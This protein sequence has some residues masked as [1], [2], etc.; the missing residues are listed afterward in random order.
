MALSRFVVTSG[1][2][3]PPETTET[4]IAAEPATHGWDTS[5]SPADCAPGSDGKYNGVPL[6]L[7][8]GNVVVADPTPGSAAPQLLYQAIRA[9]NL[10][11][12]V[13]GQDKY[14]GT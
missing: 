14:P 4:I 3:I 11:A 7:W 2:T 9:G 6:S 10:R 8:P 5:G 1:V 12:F 13:D